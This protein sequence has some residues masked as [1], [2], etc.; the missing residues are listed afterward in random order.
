MTRVAKTPKNKKFPETKKTISANTQGLPPPKPQTTDP[1]L[2]VSVLLS[3]KSLKTLL[4]E[5]QMTP[6]SEASLALRCPV[7]VCRIVDVI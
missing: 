1:R 7:S 6:V 3:L 5:L 4:N 2:D